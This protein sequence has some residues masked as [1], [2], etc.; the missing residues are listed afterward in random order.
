MKVSAVV[1]TYNRLTMLQEVIQALQA[2]ETPVQHLI[3]V[4]N[5]SNQETQ[6]YLNSLGNT[7]SYVRLNENLGGAGGFNRG[8]RYFMEQTNDDYVWLMD[9][10]TVPHEN[11][12]TELMTKAN[13]LQHFGFLSSDVRWIDGKRALMNKPATKGTVVLDEE[14]TSLVPLR[15][16]TFVSLLMSREVIAQ[17]GLPITEFFIWGDDIEYTERAERLYPGYLVPTA[18]VTHKMATNVGSNIVTD[19]KD[20]TS[21]YYYSYRNKIY[22]GR[23][24]DFVGHLKSNARITIELMKLLVTPKV[25]NRLG[26]LKVLASGVVDGMKFNPKIEFANKKN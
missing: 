5:N 2:S 23:K 11:T 3:V 15:N 6:D 1:V 17:I 10:D 20:R 7:I 12:L 16:A 13:E 4:D 19:T 22:Y 24:R 25:E 8:V 9:D 18:K 26:K 14:T 21:R